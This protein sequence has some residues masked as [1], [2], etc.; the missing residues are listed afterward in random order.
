MLN[1]LLGRQ[2]IDTAAA[3]LYATAASMARAPRLYADLKVA[4]T[5]D[6][7]LD[8][9]LLHLAIL[10]DRL[11]R[12]GPKGQALA[13]ALTE[14]FVTHI[15]DTLRHVGVGDLA[16][17]RKVK[18]AAAALYDAHQDYAPALAAGE[19]ASS[20]WRH[21]LHLHLVSRGAAPAADIPA[22]AD[23]AQAVAANLRAQADAD[24]L[25]GRIS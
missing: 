22:L 21:A 14:A 7:R 1:W 19:D 9:L 3:C 13:T 10:I 12:I 23:Y 11:G 24:L 17:P 2:G 6:G 8:M 25:A 5:V 15:D 16:V 20:A 4:D 18:K